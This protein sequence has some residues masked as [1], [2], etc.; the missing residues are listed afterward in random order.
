MK[1]LTITLGGRTYHPVPVGKDGLFDHERKALKQ[2]N[3][4][5]NTKKYGKH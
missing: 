4:Q 1:P 5:S 2:L 3:K